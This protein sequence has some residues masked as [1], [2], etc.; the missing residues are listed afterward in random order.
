MAY[1]AKL[2]NAGGVSTVTRYVDMLAGNATFIENSYESIAT[3]TVG[4]STVSTVTFS[5]I[6]ATY[7]HLQ[8][9]VMILNAS[10][11]NNLAL[12]FNADATTSYSGHQM[13]G[14]GSTV[15]ANSSTSST[16]MNLNGLVQPSSIYPFVNVIDILDYANTSKNKTIRC[17]SGQDGNG[18]G[19]ATNWRVQLSS[20]AYYKTDAINSVTLTIDPY[21]IGQYSS[22]ALYGIRG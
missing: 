18:S 5:S 11:D 8:I 17:L 7:T 15:A 6:P 19:T 9:R 22:F 21:T 10:S 14:N 3:T 20:G 12:R 16:Y 2:T 4:T 1:I 13:Q